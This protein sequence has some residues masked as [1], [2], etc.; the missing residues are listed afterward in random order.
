ME[1]S[2]GGLLLASRSIALGLLLIVGVAS[3]SR[4]QLTCMDCCQ[5]PRACTNNSGQVGDRSCNGNGACA[6]NRGAVGDNNCNGEH[7]SCADNSGPI[8][9]TELLYR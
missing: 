9:R 2:H 3:N 7:Q 1:K 4:A 6:E 5:G 8:P